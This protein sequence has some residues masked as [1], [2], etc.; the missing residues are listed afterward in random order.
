MELQ[1]RPR[2]RWPKMLVTLCVCVCVFLCISSFDPSMRTLRGGA[3]VR[4]LGKTPLET[5]MF[6]FVFVFY[7]FLIVLFCFV[8]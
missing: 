5:I 7:Y 1:L 3:S 8:F 2:G 4:E 6:E